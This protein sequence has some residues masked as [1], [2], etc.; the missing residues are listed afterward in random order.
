MR[1]DHKQ[2]KSSLMW[3]IPTSGLP[4][5]LKDKIR[6]SE[7][8]LVA[9]IS[10]FR[11][12]KTPK[13]TLGLC[14]IDAILYIMWHLYIP[15][16]NTYCTYFIPWALEKSSLSLEDYVWSCFIM[17]NSTCSHSTSPWIIQPT[18]FNKT[19]FSIMLA[20]TLSSY[21]VGEQN[22]KLILTVWTLKKK[23]NFM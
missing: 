19:G 14:Y 2:Q 3:H 7:H 23:K 12:K 15:T 20:L 18:L 17:E 1:G 16:E 11:L 21:C 13:K 22:R 6:E 10:C 5:W 9:E 4:R 8:L